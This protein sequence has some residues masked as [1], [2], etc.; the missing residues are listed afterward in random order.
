MAPTK[1][2][3]LAVKKTLRFAREGY[4]L[5]EQKREFLVMELMHYVGRVRVLEKEFS[6]KTRRLRELYLQALARGG[7][8]NLQEKGRGV[9]PGYEL[10]VREYSVMGLVLPSVTC[11]AKPLAEAP[12][13]GHGSGPALDA[14]AAA[15][16]DL[17]ATLG[18]LAGVKTSV[19]HLAR[20]VK[21]TQRRVNALDKIVIPQNEETARFIG[22]VLEENE[23]EAFFVTKLVRDR[24]R[25]REA[26]KRVAKMAVRSVAGKG[27]S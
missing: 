3:L 10:N 15:F 9:V 4:E 7:L 21:R 19:W 6:V 12:F 27:A 5:L 18:E 16:H 22:N 13:A 1:S 8:L 25:T 11:L 24:T 14:L 26:A 20:E 17:L 2:A 23:R